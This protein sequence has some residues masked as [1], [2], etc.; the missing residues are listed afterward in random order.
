M[1]ECTRSF[2]SNAVESPGFAGLW[3]YTKGTIRSNAGQEA[4]YV[5]V[6]S[7]LSI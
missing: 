5:F 2:A 6:S 1:A 3:I 7:K 4:F